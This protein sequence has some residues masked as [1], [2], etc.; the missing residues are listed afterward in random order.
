MHNNSVASSIPEKTP[1]F[2]HGLTSDSGQSL[3][4][5]IGFVAI[6]NVKAETGRIG[7]N[8]PLYQIMGSSSSGTKLYGLKPKNLRDLTDDGTLSQIS[9]R[10]DN[11]MARYM[12]MQ[13]FVA[14]CLHRI[15]NQTEGNT[16]FEKVII[17][18]SQHLTQDNLDSEIPAT[19]RHGAGIM[20]SDPGSRESNVARK[21]KEMMESYTGTN[22]TQLFM[23]MMMER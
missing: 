4:G 17:S 18:G 5:K 21:A 13:A 15:N 11:K 8:V 23:E 19:V 2:I 10:K 3:N 16:S 20:I 14:S 9:G 12:T 1:V 22:Q 7:V 6:Q